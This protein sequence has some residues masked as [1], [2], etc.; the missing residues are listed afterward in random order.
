MADGLD[1][2]TDRAAFDL[3]GVAPA[4]SRHLG[5]VADQG[6]ELDRLPFL[7]GGLT[8]EQQ[9]ALDGFAAV[10]RGLGGGAE[11]VAQLFAVRWLAIERSVGQ[12]AV[13]RHQ[14]QRLIQIVGDA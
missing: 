4:W 2:Q 10:H 1:V 6:S 14:H 8:G 9:Q 11:Q 13:A 5:D 12:V 3:G 7:L